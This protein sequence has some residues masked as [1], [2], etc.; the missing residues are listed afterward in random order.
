MI[1]SLKH[2]VT[3]FFNKASTACA[4]LVSPTNLSLNLYKGEMFMEL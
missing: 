4:F 3:I 2:P 1:P